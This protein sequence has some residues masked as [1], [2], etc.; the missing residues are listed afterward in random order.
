VTAK[1]GGKVTYEDRSIFTPPYV[2]RHY[3]LKG[4][5]TIEELELNFDTFPPTHCFEQD[6]NCPQDALKVKDFLTEVNSSFIIILDT[7]ELRIFQ[8]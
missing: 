6:N 1:N 7:L 3:Y 5:S 2:Q 4:I 8:H